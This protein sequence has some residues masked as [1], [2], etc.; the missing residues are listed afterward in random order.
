MRAFLEE[1]LKA[2]IQFLRYLEKT[3]E[4]NFYGEQP[5]LVTRHVEKFLL[6]APN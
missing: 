6:K 1:Q 4:D 2:I 3:H 5:S